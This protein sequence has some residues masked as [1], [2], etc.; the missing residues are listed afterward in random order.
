MGASSEKREFC[1]LY[2]DQYLPQWR[3]R[4]IS[5]LVSQCNQENGAHQ[6][7]ADFG[8]SL[9][10]ETSVALGSLYTRAKKQTDSFAH[11]SQHSSGTFFLTT[12]SQRWMCKTALSRFLGIKN[13]NFICDSRK[14]ST[15]CFSARQ[16][17]VS[18]R[19]ERMARSPKQ[20]RQK[21][22]ARCPP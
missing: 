19:R 9:W 13:E 16:Q 5:I 22:R 15:Q 6:W 12:Q 21:S 17:T 10:L 20:S 11:R 14:S 8:A 1:A 18:S 2:V 7:T 4:T 3:Q